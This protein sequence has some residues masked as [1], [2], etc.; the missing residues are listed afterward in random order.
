MRIH[1]W[2]WTPEWWSNS[3]KSPTI[4][5]RNQP[6]PPTS[7]FQYLLQDFQPAASVNQ[8]SHRF[9]SLNLTENGDRQE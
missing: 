5:F 3:A 4:G 9:V 1:Q 2:R 7:P 6:K 8:L